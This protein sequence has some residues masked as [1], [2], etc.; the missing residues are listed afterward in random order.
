[1]LVHVDLV[2]LRFVVAADDGVA[3]AVA[4]TISYFRCCY[5]CHCC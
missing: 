3:A 4:I 2:V 1:M 5:C